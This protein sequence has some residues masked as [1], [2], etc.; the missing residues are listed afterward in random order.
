[1]LVYP[2]I[3]PSLRILCELCLFVVN[4][5]SAARLSRSDSDS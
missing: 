2:Q 4:L 3:S 5:G 1:M